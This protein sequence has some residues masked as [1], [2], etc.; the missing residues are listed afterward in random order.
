M[1][2]FSILYFDIF[3][4][5][6]PSGAGE[7]ELEH[8]VVV[9]PTGIAVFY[10][11]QRLCCHVNTTPD[12]FPGPQKPSRCANVESIPPQSWIFVKEMQ[13]EID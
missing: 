4:P 6:K 10:G 13:R 1:T 12:L 8:Q 7:D 11:L 2:V 9:W 5:Y 3:H